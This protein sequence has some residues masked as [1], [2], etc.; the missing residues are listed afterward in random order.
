MIENNKS[1]GNSITYH[2]TMYFLYFRNIKRIIFFSL[3]KPT[4]N[5]KG[6][7]EIDFIAPS[8]AL[9]IGGRAG[10]FGTQWE[11]GEVTTFKRSDLPFLKKLLETPVEE[12]QVGPVSVK[13]VGLSDK[14][15]K[16][17]FSLVKNGIGPV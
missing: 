3:M 6:E 14:S 8:M 7:K 15:S 4:I 10:R 1:A 16:N 12:I 5:E 17:W 2:L 9:Q 13:Y 11:E